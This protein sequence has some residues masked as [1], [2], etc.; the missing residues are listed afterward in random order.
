MKFSRSRAIAAA[1]LP[2]AATA[3]LLA[4]NAEAARRTPPPAPTPSVALNPAFGAAAGG[5]ATARANVPCPAGTDSFRFT[6]SGPG[7]F[8]VFGS[9]FLGTPLAADRIPDTSV[10]GQQP[11]FDTD[12]VP[13]DGETYQIGAQCLDGAF[14]ITP[15]ASVDVKVNQ[16]VWSTLKPVVYAL[17]TKIGSLRLALVAYTGFAGGEQVSG[18]LRSAD[19]TTVPITVQPQGTDQAG[20]GAALVQIPASVADGSYTLVL[21]GAQ[22]KSAGQI[23]VTLDTTR[24][25]W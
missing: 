10:Y 25:W 13:V 5:T 6:V 19:G 24:V 23:A 11:L 8:T 1:I 18:A 17:P 9:D 22:S 21:T 4:P 12:S 14:N 15:L 3:A 20:R 16:G 2:L 7:V